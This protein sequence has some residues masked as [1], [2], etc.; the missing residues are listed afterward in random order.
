MMMMAVMFND[1]DEIQVF[2]YKMRQ[3]ETDDFSS[4]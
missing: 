4:D 3:N 1:D 2:Q